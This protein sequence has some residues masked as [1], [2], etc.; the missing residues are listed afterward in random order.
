M[1]YAGGEEWGHMCQLPRTL[2]RRF[3]VQV[4]TKWKEESGA[5]LVEAAFAIPVLLMLLMGIFTFGRAYNVYQTITRA[6]REGARERV[7]T[8]CATCSDALTPYSSS[9]VKSNFV[10]P[11]L[12]ASSLDPT[13]IQNYSTTY[14][15]LDP[16]DPVP[17]ICGIQISFDYPY[18]FSLPF[19]SINLSTINLSTKVQMRLENQPD[20]SSQ[21]MES[22]CTGSAP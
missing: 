4:V 7:M 9:Y 13:K 19:T 6:A 21:S 17:H 16:D 5:E 1:L 11:A 18:T 10:D 20:T 22:L 3:C 8:G 14:V 12:K 2:F 15:I